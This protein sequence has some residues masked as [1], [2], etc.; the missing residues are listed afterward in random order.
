VPDPDAGVP[1]ICDDP[2]MT[3]ESRRAPPQS[4]GQQSP[5][6]EPPGSP[7]PLPGPAGLRGRETGRREAASRPGGADTAQVAMLVALVAMLAALAWLAGPHSVG[8][9]WPLLVAA[10]G[11]V[12]V[13]RQADPA[14]WRRW[15]SRLARIQ[16]SWMRG[17]LGAVLVAGGI[18]GFLASRGQLSQARPGLAAAGAIVVGVAVI[19]A[20][21]LLRLLREL[22]TERGER[23]RAAERAELAAQMHDSVLHTLTM[24]QRSAHDPR[25]VHRLARTAERELRAWL[26]QPPGDTRARLSTE[27]ERLAGDVEDVHAVPIDVICVGD[28]ELGARTSAALLAA[29]EAMVNAAKYSGAAQISVYAEAEPGRL[30]VFVRDRGRG[31]D[32][33]AIPGNRMGIRQSIIGRMDRCGGTAMV[34]SAPGEGTEVEIHVTRN[35]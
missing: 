10:I 30:S 14:L 35:A 12:L 32:L 19:A 27:L 17:L 8:L 7:V 18:A 3:Q 33:D 31:F 25:Y 20:P 26:N 34:K 22:D 1:G 5:G 13:W 6:Q 24:I 16:P 23:I 9:L 2:G 21:W 11:A 28:L 15:N 29:R 4:P